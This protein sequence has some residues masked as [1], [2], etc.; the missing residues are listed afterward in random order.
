MSKFLHLG[1]SLEQV[2][3]RTTSGPARILGIADRLATLRPGAEG[4]LCVLDLREGEHAFID[5]ARQVEIG[6]R[7]IAPIHVIKAGRLCS[8]GPRI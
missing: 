3:E 6:A 4:D 2:I 7:R 5:C 8:Q 1:L